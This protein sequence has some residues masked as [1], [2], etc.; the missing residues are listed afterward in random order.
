MNSAANNYDE[1]EI[2]KFDE[3]AN[4][5][6]DPTGEFKPLHQL[7]PVRTRYVTD[8][9][10]VESQ[11]VLDV[12][13]GGGL[14]TEAL[15]TAGANV[16]GIDMAPGPLSVARLH[17]HKSGLENIR[18]LQTHAEALAADEA[19]QF[20]VVTC[21]EVIE[22]VPDPGSLITACAE[23][24]R[25]GGDLFFSTLNRNLKS[26]LLAIVGAEYVMNM[27]PKGTHE[28]DKFIKPSELRRWAREAGL[29]LRDISGISYNPVNGVFTLGDDV[30]V[31]YL[32]HFRK[33]A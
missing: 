8:R 5:W 31:N 15:A 12:G 25:P 1:R 27:L 22:H 17:Q 28:Y 18:Y 16:T 3:L 32:M 11:P 14:L 7:N 10:H 29:E 33:P 26:F 4:R 2:G 9:A 21:M 23:L 6:W 20:A 24:T 30:D 13:C 19:E